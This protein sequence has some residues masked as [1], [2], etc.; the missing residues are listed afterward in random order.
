MNFVEHH[1]CP[2]AIL[3]RDETKNDITLQKVISKTQNQR[4]EI[5]IE[6]KEL[7][8]LLNLIPELTL[9]PDGILLK[10]N[11]ITIP[12]ELQHRAIELAHDNHLGIAKTIAL[13]REK[14]YFVNME[15]KEKAKISV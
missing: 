8:I 10:Q 6:K 3:I 13:R 7:K 15:E 9:T 4:E 11:R 12:N 5:N 1:V 14:I 2:E